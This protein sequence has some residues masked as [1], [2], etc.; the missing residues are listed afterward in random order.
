MATVSVDGVRRKLESA[1][2]HLADLGARTMALLDANEG[3]VI[4]Q[5]DPQ[6]GDYIFRAP[7]E[8]APLEWGILTGLWAHLLRSSL[9]NL[10]WAVI[11]RRG[12]RGDYRTQFPIWEG[13]A[14][15]RTGKLIPFNK[16]ES[17]FRRQAEPWTRG[18]DP[19]DLTFI[20]QSQPYHVARED[21]RKWHPLALLAHLN[22]MDKHRY[23]QP[24][25]AA[26]SVWPTEGPNA[27]RKYFIA[28]DPIKRLGLG[29]G[30][31]PLGGLPVPVAIDGVKSMG[32][33]NFRGSDDDPA[34][35]V[36]VESVIPK[37]GVEPKWR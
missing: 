21:I 33:F 26:A 36:R 18:V 22:N 17:E 25:I 27:G 11:E 13:F 30:V 9:D 28:A 19:E 8:P 35:V 5:Y 6:T 37:D 2:Q 14:D 16:C 7:A 20:E 29:P 3:G 15:Y 32:G 12:G 10:L 34:E 4:G 1:D 23:T 24:F 31:I